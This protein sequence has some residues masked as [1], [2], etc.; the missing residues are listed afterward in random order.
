M[1]SKKLS[2]P[3]LFSIV[4]DFITRLRFSLVIS[5]YRQVAVIIRSYTMVNFYFKTFIFVSLVI[6]YF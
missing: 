2:A 6:G 3:S 5:Y 1:L 4:P